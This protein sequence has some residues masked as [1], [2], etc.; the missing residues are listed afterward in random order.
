[1]MAPYSLYSALLLTRAHKTL[2]CYGQGV[3]SCGECLESGPHCAWC[4]EEVL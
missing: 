3:K 4:K 2:E 1:Q